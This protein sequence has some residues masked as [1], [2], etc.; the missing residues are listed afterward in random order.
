MKTQA[1]CVSLYRRSNL[2]NFSNRSQIPVN[3]RIRLHTLIKIS[4]DGRPMDK[5]KI[6]RREH[7]II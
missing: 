2:L 3:I 5:R 4:Y 7:L 6:K 1:E